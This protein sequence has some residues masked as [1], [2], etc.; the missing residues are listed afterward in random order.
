MLRQFRVHMGDQLDFDLEADN[1]RQFRKNFESWGNVSFPKA[2]VSTPEVLV[3]SFEPGASIAEFIKQKQRDR[4]RE[5]RRQA[6]LERGVGENFD[7]KRLAIHGISTESVA[8]VHA[9]ANTSGAAAAGAVSSSTSTPGAST[10]TATAPTG[11]SD[12]PPF[13]RTES[14]LDYRANELQGELVERLGTIGLMALLKMIIVDNFIHAD[15]HPGNVFVRHYEQKGGVLTRLRENLQSW[16]LGL[17]SDVTTLPN[18]C[19]LDAAPLS[20]SQSVGVGSGEGIRGMVFRK[21]LSAHI[22]P[23]LGQNV[24]GFFRAMLEY[25]GG[26]LAEEILALSA[27]NLGNLDEN[28]RRSF[29]QELTAKGHVSTITLEGWQ[30]ELDPSINIMHHVDLTL[31]QHQVWGNRMAKVDEAFQNVL[32]F[33][34]KMTGFLM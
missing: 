12:A 16:I 4:D 14:N 32:R 29:I 11:R 20:E 9:G 7:E 6:L 15:L 21:G 33:G 18:V 17:G 25:D 34:N 19:F 31:K 2:S 30:Y 10:S 8:V 23:S 3:E 26:R 22:E 27:K 13:G 1:L 24:R 5:K 28:N